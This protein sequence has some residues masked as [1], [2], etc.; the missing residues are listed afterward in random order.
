MVLKV[1]KVVLKVVK[2]VPVLMAVL[3][4]VPVL[5]AVLVLMMVLMVVLAVKLVLAVALVEPFLAETFLVACPFLL[6]PG[7]ALQEVQSHLWPEQF[8]SV[9]ED[10]R[11]LVFESPRRRG[12][13]CLYSV[14]AMTWP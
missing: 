13:V 6:E 10:V 12:L 7:L 9:Q 11:H 8:G 14:L 4:A 3:I 1:V 5:V 2:V